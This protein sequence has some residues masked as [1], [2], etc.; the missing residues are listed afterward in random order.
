MKRAW[1]GT[2]HFE[3]LLS[4]PDGWCGA[5][6]L[7]EAA[8]GRGKCRPPAGVPVAE[9]PGVKGGVATESGNVKSELN[10]GQP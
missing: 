9:A 6:A 10:H 4:N 2:I 8:L 5:G 7:G 1:L 3:S